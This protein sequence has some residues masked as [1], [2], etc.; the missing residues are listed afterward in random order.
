MAIAEQVYIA[1]AKHLLPKQSAIDHVPFDREKVLEFLPHLSEIVDNYPQFQ[2]PGYFKAKLLLAL[3]DKEHM[4]ESLLP[5]ARKKRNDFWVWEILSECFTDD[6]EKV[7]SCLCKALSC[8]SPEEML[9]NVR[10]KM[11]ALLVE[12]KSYNE[13]KT[14]IDLLVKSREARGYSIPPVIT[15]CKKQEW[16]SSAIGMDS[17]AVLYKKYAP[18]ADAI[19]FSDIPEETIIVD[20]V[21]KDKKIANFIASEQKFG[22][23]KYDRFLRAVNLGDILKVRFQGGSNEG[24]HQMYTVFKSTDDSFKSK[25]IKDVEGVVKISP[26]KSF[27]FLGDIYIHPSIVSKLKLKDGMHFKGLA[28]KSYNKEKMLWTFKLI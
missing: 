23:F 10:Q 1:Y 21:N 15:S 4:L 14:E 24:M 22:F 20:F 11:A 9:I 5:F 16:Y 7:F 18:E 19:I 26:G 27:G 2:Y 17:N 8:T 6:K 28:I 25:F 3:G 12:K 13:A